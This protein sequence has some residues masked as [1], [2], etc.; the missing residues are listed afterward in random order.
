M[1]SI[2]LLLSNK[3]KI[4]FYVGGAANGGTY[5]S[6]LKLKRYIQHGKDC[7]VVMRNKSSLFNSGCIFSTAEKLMPNFKKIVSDSSVV[8]MADNGSSLTFLI[9][10]DFITQ[11]KFYDVVLL[12]NASQI[13]ESYS[14]ISFL[15]KAKDQLIVVS[16]ST[17][18]RGFVFNN[19][20]DFL[21]DCGEYYI[22]N[23][24]LSGVSIKGITAI[25]GTCKDNVEFLKNNETYVKQLSCL[26]KKDFNI[27]F[28]GYYYK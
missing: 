17:K 10:D 11:D 1:N 2:D 14:L 24:A 25:H 4:C 6:L 19:L 15:L 26:P 18:T 5:T 7:A 8:L 27:L 21:L 28:H 22:F 3:D 23:P 20:S 16:N 9:C 13:D 12:D